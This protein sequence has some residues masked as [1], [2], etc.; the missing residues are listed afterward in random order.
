MKEAEFKALK[1]DMARAVSDA[2]ERRWRAF[3]NGMEREK[4]RA[5]GVKRVDFLVG[6]TRVD[7][8]RK[9]VGMKE[10]AWEFTVR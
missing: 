9:V 4:E 1:P 3:K 2:F 5:K 10:D 7:G 6:K 8:V